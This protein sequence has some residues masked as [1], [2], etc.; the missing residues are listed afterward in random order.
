MSLKS[1]PFNTEPSTTTVTELSIDPVLVGLGI[2]GNI[3]SASAQDGYIGLGAVDPPEPGANG[4][5]A[6]DP[7]EPGAN[8]CP[9]I[10]NI[11]LLAS[12]RYSFNAAIFASSAIF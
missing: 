6:V 7:P 1:S 11:G 9:P 4:V 5:A 12:A 8:G 3:F 10:P 2:T